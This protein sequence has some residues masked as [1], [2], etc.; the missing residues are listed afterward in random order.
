MFKN[1]IDITQVSEFRLKTLVYFGCGAIHKI[2]DIADQLA[3]RDIKNILVVSGRGAYKATGAWDV[4]VPALE[5]RGI[6]YTLF[7]KVG[8]F[9]NDVSI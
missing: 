3:A 2:N 1:N 6:A 5:S 9:F 8:Y 7:E 4:I